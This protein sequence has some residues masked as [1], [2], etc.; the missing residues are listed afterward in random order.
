MDKKQPHMNPETPSGEPT[1][2]LPLVDVLEDENG[3]TVKADLPGV[4]PESLSIRVDGE[5][6][7][8]EGSVALGEAQRMEAVYAEV[9]VAQYKRSFVLSRDLDTSRIDASLRD[10]VLNLQMPKL[11]RAR[12]RRIA[13]RAE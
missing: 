4:S 11:E 9:K 6:L 5:T 7:T 3:I 8:I 1:A 10:G 13:V 12:P 2:L